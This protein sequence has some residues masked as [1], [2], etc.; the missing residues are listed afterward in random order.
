MNTVWGLNLRIFGINK[1]SFSLFMIYVMFGIHKDSCMF[2]SFVRK[3][4]MHNVFFSEQCTLVSLL[5]GVFAL[6]CLYYLNKKTWISQWKEDQ[7]QIPFQDLIGSIQ[8]NS[9]LREDRGIWDFDN[10]F[11]DFLHWKW[12]P[13]SLHPLVYLSYCLSYLFE[14]RDSKCL[15]QRNRWRCCWSLNTDSNNLHMESAWNT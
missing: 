1:D 5:F 8:F 12:H 9:K 13:L 10:F 3:K 7:I 2:D 6:R 4:E 15:T 14:V 11:Y